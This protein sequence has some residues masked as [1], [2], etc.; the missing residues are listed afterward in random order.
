MA[1]LCS[2]QPK[3]KQPVAAPPAPAA[4]AAARTIALA[5]ARGASRTPAV[6][7]QTLAEPACTAGASRVPDSAE[8]QGAVGPSPAAQEQNVG[9]GQRQAHQTAAHHCDSDLHGSSKFPQSQVGGKVGKSGSEQH[10]MGSSRRGTPV[11]PL[12]VGTS[13]SC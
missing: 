6:R 3:Q 11:S 1:D 5:E 9:G 2:Q 7:E 12:S 8:E 4:P 13:G 10:A